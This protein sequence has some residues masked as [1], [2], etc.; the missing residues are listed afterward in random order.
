MCFTSYEPNAQNEKEENINIKDSKNIN[1]K[2]VN[3][4]SPK[5]KINSEELINKESNSSISTLFS[6]KDSIN[7]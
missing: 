3:Q 5:K 2:N 7:K 1:S 6:L 4:K